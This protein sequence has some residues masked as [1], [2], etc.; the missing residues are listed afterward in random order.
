MRP[1]IATVARDTL[2][3]GISRGDN[4]CL[5]TAVDLDFDGLLAPAAYRDLVE[6][7]QRGG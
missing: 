7:E 6:R 2:K 4:D 3:L 1:F 5:E